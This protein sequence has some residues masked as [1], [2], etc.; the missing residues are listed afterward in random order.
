MNLSEYRGVSNTTGLEIEGSENR[1]NDRQKKM[2]IR[3]RKIIPGTWA[4][5]LL[6]R[7]MQTL[8]SHSEIHV[9]DRCE[10]GRMAF[11]QSTL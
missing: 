4:R 3:P 11:A 2:K 8:S 9:F 10:C 6:T 5:P 7:P 1:H